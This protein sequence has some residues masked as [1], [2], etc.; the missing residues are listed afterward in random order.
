VIPRVKVCGITRMEDARLAAD[1]GASALGF[2]FW[3]D[4]PRFVEPTIAR[5]IAAALPP[6]VVCVGVFVDQDADYVRHASDQVPLGAVQLHG[7]E[8]MEFATGLMTPVIKAVPVRDGFDLAELDALPPIITVLLDA[9]DAARHGGTGKTI[10]WKLARQAARRRPIVLSGGLTPENVTAAVDAV[11][12]YAVDV[13]SGVES[14]P[15]IK[16]PLKLIAFF[17]ALAARSESRAHR[18]D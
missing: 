7:R 12:P 11:G 4:S 1:L 14:A 17:K 16:D 18:N 15:G 10:D 3:P 9:Y 2:V 8:S 5:E 13:S 6:A